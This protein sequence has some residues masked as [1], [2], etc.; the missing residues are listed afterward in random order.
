MMHWVTI[1]R[2]TEHVHCPYAPTK[3]RAITKQQQYSRLLR[4]FAE[5][6]PGLNLAHGL[7]R[8]ERVSSID[9]L[10]LGK[11]EGMC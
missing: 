7:E 5:I 11:L 10:R 6:A 8:F 4:P 2:G 9:P 3:L 1:T